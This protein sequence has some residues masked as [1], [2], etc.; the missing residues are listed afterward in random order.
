MPCINLT[1]DTV[2]NALVNDVYT[3]FGAPLVLLTDQGENFLSKTMDSIYLAM[4]IE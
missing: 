1:S 3:K 2:A 4:N